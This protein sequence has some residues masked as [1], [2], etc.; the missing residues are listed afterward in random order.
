MSPT[1]NTI[2]LFV[3]FSNVNAHS[4]RSVNTQSSNLQPK[5]QYELYKALVGETVR[6][7]CPQ[8]NPTW[9][10]RRFSDSSSSNNVEDIIVTRHGIINSD[11]KYKIMCHMTLKHKVIL[12]NNIDFGEEGLYTCLYTLPPNT[13]SK[14]NSLDDM[15]TNPVQFRYVFNVTVYTLLSGL[16][17]N[18]VPDSLANVAKNSHDFNIKKIVNQPTELIENLL[19][20]RE[21]NQFSLTCI[22]DSSKPAADIQFLIKNKNTGA[23]K[24][25]ILSLNN[26]HFS[27]YLTLSPSTQAPKLSSLINEESNYSRNND[28]TFKTVHLAHLKANREDNGKTFACVAENGFSNQ[29]WEIKK[30][31]NVLYA[32]VCKDPP[33]FVYYVGINQTVNVECRILNANPSRISY[34]WNLENIKK[35][36]RY[37][38]SEHYD[39]V[40]DNNFVLKRSYFATKP[41]FNL[42]RDAISFQNDDFKSRFK[43]RPTDST[44][45]GKISCKATNDIATTQ[46]NYEIKLG[47][48]PN[49]PTD[50]AYTLKNSSAIISCIV[51]FHQGDPDI[52]CYLLKKS[53]NEVYKEHTRNR[54][55]CSFIVNDVN[56]NKLNEFWIYSSNKYGHNKDLGFHLSIGQEAKHNESVSD[57]EPYNKANLH[58]IKGKQVNST[59]L[60]KGVKIGQNY[61]NENEVTDKYSK[62]DLPHDYLVERKN[63]SLVYEKSEMDYEKRK[64]ESNYEKKS[65]TMNKKKPKLIET[66]IKK[67]ISFLDDMNHTTI[68]KEPKSTANLCHATFDAQNNVQNNVQISMSSMNETNTNNGSKMVTFS[69]QRSSLN[70]GL[71]TNSENHTNTTVSTSI[72]G[73]SDSAESPNSYLS[74]DSDCADSASLFRHKLTVSDQ[75]FNQTNIF[76]QNSKFNRMSTFSQSNSKVFRSPRHFIEAT[77]QALVSSASASSSSSSSSTSHNQQSTVS[78]SQDYSAKLSDSFE[79]KFLN[80]LCEDIEVSLNVDCADDYSVNDFSGDYSFDNGT[81]TPIYSSVAGRQYSMAQKL[82]QKM[83]DKTKSNETNIALKNNKSIVCQSSSEFN[84]I[85]KPKNLNKN[86]LGVL[87]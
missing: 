44:Q 19:T 38:Q 2:I 36:S 68:N 28:H 43:W 52:Y 46:C 80:K 41:I 24:N 29:K 1:I 18:Y 47:G 7:E 6:L 84:S 57:H 64:R 73:S 75:S 49:P 21:G 40:N 56:L 83:S 87:V 9:F 8:P 58:G 34:D 45:F 13:N 82:T 65:I 30:T 23:L 39:L 37:K 74:N 25:E 35:P 33:N 86:N 55:S 5:I 72:S 4:Q 12:I 60:I 61:S 50:C 76:L 42:K 79:A 22:V 53:E 16:K 67:S 85:E 32:P 14:T 70:K 31:L 10:F 63:A 59:K 71:N 51:G 15:L 27:S 78:N 48:V 62:I 77:P 17:M 20:V 81:K 69:Q 3:L 66:N 26:N 11:Y 54:E